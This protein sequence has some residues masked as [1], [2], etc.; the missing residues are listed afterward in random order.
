[1]SSGGGPPAPPPPELEEDSEIDV[2]PTPSEAEEESLPSFRSSV[3]LR[4]TEFRQ[5]CSDACVS[6]AEFEFNC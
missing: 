3:A 5:W 1:M 6:D 2:T 4:F